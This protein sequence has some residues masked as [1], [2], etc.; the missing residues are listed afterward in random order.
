M[1]ETKAG[2]EKDPQEFEPL[3]DSHEAALLMHL[4]PETLKRMARHGKGAAVKFGRIWRFR[5]S[6]LEECIQQLTQNKNGGTVPPMAPS[7]SAVCVVRNRR[8]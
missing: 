8:N 6:A 7:E 2:C 3:L 1:R 4:H 5:R